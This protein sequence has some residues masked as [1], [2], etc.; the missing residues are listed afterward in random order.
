MCR[1]MSALSTERLSRSISNSPCQVTWIVR[2]GSAPNERHLGTYS[3][4]HR[5]GMVLP[6]SIFAFFPCK[7]HI[8]FRG[9]QAFSNT[10]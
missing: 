10:T 4:S 5:A 6:G 7:D 2:T 8:S 1:A 3:P 9:G